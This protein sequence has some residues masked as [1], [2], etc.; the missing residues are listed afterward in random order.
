MQEYNREEVEKY[1]NKNIIQS[2]KCGL[3]GWKFGIQNENNFKFYLI[4]FIAFLII[5]L[6]IVKINE[7]QLILYLI[8]SLSTIAIEF[9]NTAIEEI[10]N[11]TT[12]EFSSSIKNIKDLGSAADLT[13]GILF[14]GVEAYWI[15]KIFIGW[16][17]NNV[18]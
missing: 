15:I 6:A 8:I 5:N 3:A 11:S 10:C 4:N 17:I 16:I 7:T 13:I 14:Y 18:K 9:V 2:I 12:T 1:R